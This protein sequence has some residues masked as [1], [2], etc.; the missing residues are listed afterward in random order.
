M[1]L[2][3]LLKAYRHH[4]LRADVIRVCLCKIQDACTRES[5]S[6]FFF[7]CAY[8]ITLSLKDSTLLKCR[9]RFIGGTRTLLLLLLSLS[10]H[11]SHS[12]ASLASLNILLRAGKKQATLCKESRE[13]V[14]P[15]S[16]PT[17]SYSL[18]WGLWFLCHD[19]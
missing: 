19:L 9:Q 6:S 8:H 18:T 2:S 1:F 13:H 4:V 17:L 10:A 12:S 15:Y 11:F 3:T 5:L 7:S 16:F 14:G